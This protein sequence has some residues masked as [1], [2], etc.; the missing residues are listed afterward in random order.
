MREAEKTWWR[1]EEE[2]TAEIESIK[3][4][5]QLGALPL[6]KGVIVIGRKL[7]ALEAAMRELAAKVKK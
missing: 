2:M 6:G 3:T 5:D 7:L 1:S 4:M